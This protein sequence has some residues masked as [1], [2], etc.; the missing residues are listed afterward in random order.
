[1]TVAIF[2]RLP[3]WHSTAPTEAGVSL[4]NGRSVAAATGSRV[5]TENQLQSRKRRA[6]TRQVV[7][8]DEGNR[9]PRIAFRPLSNREGLAAGVTADAARRDRVGSRWNMTAS[10]NEPAQS[11][12]VST[13]GPRAV[14][15]LVA[16][17]PK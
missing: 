9:A 2:Q 7:T 15:P 6:P 4:P 12:F 16:T 11:T 5:A 10:A 8:K 17:R 13:A 1:M 14:T 3:R